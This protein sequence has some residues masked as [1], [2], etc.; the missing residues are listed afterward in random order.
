MSLEVRLCGVRLRNPTVLAAGVLGTSPHILKRVYDAGAGAV[1]TKSIGPREREGHPNPVVVEFECG[2]LNAVGL[3]SPPLEESVENL[4][5]AVKLVKGPV[6]AS[7]YGETAADFR[8][9]ASLVSEAE[10]AMVELNISC[11]NV[12]GRI[13]ALNPAESAKIVG[14]VRDVVKQPLIVKLS[15]TDTFTIKEVARAV[16]DAGA[17]VIAAVNTMPAMVIDVDFGRPVLSN[18][19][20]GMSGAALR[21]IAVRCVYDIYE[22]VADANV[23]IIGIGG[24]SSGRDALEMMMAGASAVGVGTAVLKGLDVF[25]RILAEM[26]E[27]LEKRCLSLAEVVGMAHGR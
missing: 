4:R 11:P 14:A 5:R 19:R 20:G 24:V 13:P 22:E 15:P 16:V 18:R 10:P 12:E 17:D 1:T 9:V 8:H 26:E 23:P 6:I 2:L 25:K 3:P 21:P 7:I 27:F